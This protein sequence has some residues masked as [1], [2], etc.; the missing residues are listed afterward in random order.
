MNASQ[1]EAK[2]PAP[3]PPQTEALSQQIATLQTAVNALTASQL[4]N[5]QRGQ[6][7]P[8]REPG[9]LEKLML[10]NRYGSGPYTGDVQDYELAPDQPDPLS[11]D[12]FDVESAAEFNHLNNGYIEREVQRRMEATREAQAKVSEKE[13]LEGQIRAA[14]AKFKRDANYK[15]TMLEALHRAGESGWKLPIEEVYLQ[16]SEEAEAKRRGSYLPKGTKTLGDIA[17]YRQQTGRIGR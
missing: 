17:R 15:E 1:A 13:I 9:E 11:H 3:A 7:A 2:A 6:A 16:V 5:M 10:H 4:A 8:E 12:F 14:D